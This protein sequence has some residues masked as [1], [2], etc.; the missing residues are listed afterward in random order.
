MRETPPSPPWGRGLAG[1]RRF[2]QPGRSGEGVK[3]VKTPYPYRQTR[4]LA[5]TAR[6][7]V[8]RTTDFAVRVFFVADIA[9]VPYAIAVSELRR[10]FLSDRYFFIVARLL[11]RREKFTAADFALLARAFTRAR[12][13]HLLFAGRGPSPRPRARHWL[14]GVSGNDCIGHLQ[15]ICRHER[16]RAKRTRCFERRSLENDLRSARTN[17][18]TPSRTETDADHKSGGPR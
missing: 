14:A 13:L 18:I 1:N 11:R 7:Q 17:L 3:P 15:R 10:P 8:A 12:G 9:T 5:L 6:R 4:S 16:P 2:H